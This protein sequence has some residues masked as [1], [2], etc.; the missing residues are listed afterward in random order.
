MFE[1]FKSRSEETNGSSTAV[2]DRPRDERAATAA[3]EEAPTRAGETATRTHAPAARAATGR[4]PGGA[5]L[6]RE[7]MDTAR[8]R[9]REEYGGVNWGAAFFGWL[10]AVGLGALLVA[11][12]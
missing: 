8:A 4:R 9:Q 12:L 6:T 2:A 3:G 1:R 11:I 10:V 7:H 5:R